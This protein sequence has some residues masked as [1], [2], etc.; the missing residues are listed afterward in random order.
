MFVS[1]WY[2]QP[3]GALPVAPLGI[4]LILPDPAYFEQLVKA[5]MLGITGAASSTSQETTHTLVH[6]V[7]NMKDMGCL[8][9][10]G[11]EDAKVAEQ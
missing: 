5:I 2:V 4:S 1:G 10:L 9:F 6:W 7:K 11:D 8:L 3:E